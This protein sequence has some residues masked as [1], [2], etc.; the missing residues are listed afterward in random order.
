MPFCPKCGAEVGSSKF[1]PECGV[2]QGTVSSQAQ[3]P[4]FK[5]SKK[6]KYNPYIGAMLCCCLSPIVMFVYYFVTESEED[7]L[8]RTFKYVIIP[9]VTF[10]G[11]TIIFFITMSIDI[12]DTLEGIIPPPFIV[13]PLMIFLGTPIVSIIVFYYLNKQNKM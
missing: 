10:V 12:Y 5:Q 1:C 3:Q 13:G 4:A 7:S 6:E 11:L 8:A 2:G 9:I